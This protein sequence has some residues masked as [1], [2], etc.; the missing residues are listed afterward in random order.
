MYD[1][2][3]FVCRGDLVEAMQQLQNA[4]TSCPRHKPGALVKIQRFINLIETH[5]NRTAEA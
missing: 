2:I 1:L 3:A 4:R 5:D